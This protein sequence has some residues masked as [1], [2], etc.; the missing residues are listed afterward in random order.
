LKTQEKCK[1]TAWLEANVEIPSARECTYLL[2]LENFTWHAGP[3]NGI[4]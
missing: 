1:L 3:K 4:N 2:F